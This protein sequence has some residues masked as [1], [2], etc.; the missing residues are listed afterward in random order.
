MQW[1]EFFSWLMDWEGRKVHY[2]PDDPGGQTAWGIAREHW[3]NW[4]GWQLVDAGITSGPRFERAVSDFYREKYRPIWDTLPERVREA[5]VDAVVNMGPGRKGD[6]LLGGVELLQ[7][8]LCRLARSR[9]VV[10]DGILGPQTR[11]AVK[12]AD[13][14]ALAFAICALRLADYGLRGKQGKV[15]RKYLDGWINRVRSLMEVL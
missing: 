8:A 7:E 5:T 4:E 10:V 14:G 1:N 3:P 9:Y 2:D 12:R 11:E 13:P 6:D 15:A